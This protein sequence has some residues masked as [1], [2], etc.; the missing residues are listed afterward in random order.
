MPSVELKSNPF[1]VQTPEE[2]SAQDTVS[3]FVDVFNDFPKV[4]HIGHS[5]IHG[6]RGSGKSMMFRFLLPDCQCLK[7]SL[8][9]DKIEFYGVYIPIKNT[10]LALTELRRLQSMYNDVV[11]N[12]HFMVMFLASRIFGSFIATVVPT[13][14]EAQR[15]VWSLFQHWKELLVEAGWKSP[16]EMPAD[17]PAADLLA[18]M[19]KVSWSLYR[20]VIQYLR[21]AAGPEIEPYN[22]PLCGYLDFLHPLARSLRKMPFMPR[23]PL[24][25]LID[26]ADNLN[27]TQTRILNS[28]VATR[29]SQD[30]SIKI[31]TQLN[32][33]TYTTNSGQRIESPHDYTEI[34]I[35]TIYTSYKNN[36]KRRISE[37]VVKRLQ[38]SGI[39]VAP[40][41]FFPPDQEQEDEIRKIGETLRSDWE[42]TGRGHRPS[43]DVVRYSRPMFIANLKGPRKAG[44]TYSYAGFEQLVHLSSGLIRYFLDPAALMYA[45]QSSDHPDQKLKSI[46]PKIQNEIVRQESENLLFDG[47]EK[48]ASE[49]DQENHYYVRVRQLSNLV[50]ALG[51]TF[52]R[53]LISPSRSERKVFSIALSDTPDKEVMEVL[54]LGIDNGYFQPSTI[55]NKE[56]TGRTRLYI[57]TRRLAPSFL[58]DPSSF[59]GYLFVTSQ[60]LREAM[61]NP[62]VARKIDDSGLEEL[63]ESKQLSLFERDINAVG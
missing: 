57:L 17:A 59:A 63:F 14:A 10:S 56:G 27:T 12:E 52:H 6:P 33:K 15:G 24:F 31:S 22:G 58:L 1:S 40:E 43:D 26:D 60:F 48:L 21:Q 50:R 8:T 55:G 47:F 37:I 49:K 46:S 7:H 19:D 32:Y 2:I 42:K 38:Q 53:V 20:H 18:K 41:D 28:W 44:S 62:N 39:E 45:K 54:K 25:L 3:L 13:D 51:R 34:N 29:T 23:G 11:L 30:I 4:P 61:L 5:F 35:S 9:L 36:Y 16:V